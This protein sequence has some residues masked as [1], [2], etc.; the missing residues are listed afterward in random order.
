MIFVFVPKN[1]SVIKCNL[2]LSEIT[3][4]DFVQCKTIIFINSDLQN[5]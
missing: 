2:F 3:M 1:V 4:C 5:F